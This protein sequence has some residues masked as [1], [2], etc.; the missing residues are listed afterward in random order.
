M[1]QAHG[2]PN[3]RLA[4]LIYPQAQQQLR[5]GLRSHEPAHHLHHFADLMID[6]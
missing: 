4:F 5:H 6:L 2:M 1:D 3:T